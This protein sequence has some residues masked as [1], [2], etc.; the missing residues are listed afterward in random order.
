[1]L[2]GDIVASGNRP[3]FFATWGGYKT[4]PSAGYVYESDELTGRCVA[5]I[6]E[7]TEL[8]EH[9][10]EQKDEAIAFVANLMKLKASPAKVQ[11]DL[12]AFLAES[13]PWCDPSV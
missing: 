8:S 9:F 3:L 13:E 6:A 12:E 2:A 5:V 7:G 1:M 11:E 10:F 4:V